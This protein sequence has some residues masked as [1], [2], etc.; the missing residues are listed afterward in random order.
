MVKAGRRAL[1]HAPLRKG[2]DP[3]SASATCPP[4][5]AVPGQDDGGWPGVRQVRQ[6]QPPALPALLLHVSCQV[7]RV[8]I[9]PECLRAAMVPDRYTYA[10]PCFLAVNFCIA[11]NGP[12]RPLPP[13]RYDPDLASFPTKDGSCALVRPPCHVRVPALLL[14][15]AG[16][17]LMQPQIKPSCP[18]HTVRCRAR[19]PTATRQRLCLAGAHRVQPAAPSVPACCC[20]AHVHARA[21]SSVC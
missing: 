14:P 2:S 7:K 5:P 15:M 16:L 6:I 1:Q 19:W 4:P 18:A 13:C 3:A 17:R 12:V 8:S 9:S 21:G 20:P 11:A 10:C